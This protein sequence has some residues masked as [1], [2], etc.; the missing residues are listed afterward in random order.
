MSW[1]RRKVGI[2]LG[3]FA[4][5]LT[6]GFVGSA[7]G[8]DERIA[9]CGGEIGDNT[10]VSAFQIDAAADIWK[11]LPAMGISP[12]LSQDS[13]PAYVVVFQDGYQPTAFAGN[14][15]AVDQPQAR[16]DGVVCVIRSDGYPILYTNVSRSGFRTPS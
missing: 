16:L 10:V 13:Q 14:P 7:L 5:V 15:F 1:Q 8:G 2:L 9:R 11:F 4:P 6:L 12:E 3:M